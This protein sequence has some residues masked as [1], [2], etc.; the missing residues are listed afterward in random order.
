MT[1]GEL[2]HDVPHARLNLALRWIAGI[3]GALLTVYV[4]LVLFG[5]VRSSSQHFDMAGGLL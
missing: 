5:Y 3:A 2:W 4:T 1:I